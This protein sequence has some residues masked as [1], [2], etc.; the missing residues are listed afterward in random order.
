MT[1]LSDIV[2]DMDAVCEMLEE[3]GWV[4]DYQCFELSATGEITKPILTVKAIFDPPRQ[5]DVL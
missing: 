3:R 2:D 4:I 1:D 5:V